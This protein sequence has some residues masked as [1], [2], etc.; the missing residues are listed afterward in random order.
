MLPDEKDIAEKQLE[1]LVDS[2]MHT[3]KL[4]STA[5]GNALND[6]LRQLFEAR[7]EQRESFARTI[8]QESW[9]V[10]EDEED[11]KGPLDVL[12]RG[13]LTIRA[14]MTIEPDKTD[15]ILIE[16]T[17]EAD[18]ALL[19]KY[20]KVLSD[21]LDRAVKATLRRQ[22]TLI[23]ATQANMATMLGTPQGQ[24]VLGLFATV[25][26]AEEAVD[27]LVEA[28][29]EQDEISVLAQEEA[30]ESLLEDPRPQ[31]TKESATAGAVGGGAVGGLLGLIAG[32]STAIV[33]GVG[34]VMTGG[35][36]AAA[37]GITAAGAGIGASYGGLLGALTGWGV[38]EG[39]I[40]HFIEGVRDGKIL[41]AVETERN[42]SE[43][44]AALMRDAG[45]TYVSTHQ[46][47]NEE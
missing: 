31:A 34:T 45:A 2:L 30:V 23:E 8:E 20:D 39:D 18:E 41:V 24:M 10:E 16:D 6:E 37:L 27:G 3:K 26:Q 29:Y 12:R 14:A 32:A 28:G 13:G 46:E 21:D 22:V 17:R 36:L 9:T 4:Y 35:A 44:A 40:Q 5:A 42:G 1:E 43:K 7:A 11:G 38:S 15:R 33:M 25:E 47:E 19:E